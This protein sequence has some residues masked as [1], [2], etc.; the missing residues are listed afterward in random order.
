MAAAAMRVTGDR[1]LLRKMA[2]LKGSVRRKII[3]RPLSSALTPI[4]KAAKRGAPKDEGD[5]SKSIG[6]KVK[7]YRG[8][9]WGGVGPRV[10]DKYTRETPD[11]RRKV[12]AN[13]GLLVE[14]GTRHSKPNPFLRR[15]LDDKRE[16]ALRILRAGTWKN[17]KAEGRKK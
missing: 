15:A 6:K 13:Y 8:G 12:P 1:A 10:G 9:V 3:R 16:E 11:G 17:L 5:L 7:L 14:L 4:S 2:R